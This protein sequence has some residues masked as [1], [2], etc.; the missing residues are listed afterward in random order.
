MRSKLAGRDPD[1]E[2][3]QASGDLQA[4]VS[5]VRHDHA[6]LHERVKRLTGEEGVKRLDAALLAARDEVA[7]ELEEA[8]SEAGSWETT[9]E[10]GRCVDWGVWWVGVGVGG[11]GGVGRTGWTADRKQQTTGFTV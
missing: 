1:S 5:Q 10:A 4:M 3:M 8:Q 2:A 11:L 6:L 7:A 9:S